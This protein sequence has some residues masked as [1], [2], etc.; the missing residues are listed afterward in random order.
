MKSSPATPNPLGVS[1]KYNSLPHTPLTCGEHVS[2]A[3]WMP[4]TKDTETYR[5]PMAFLT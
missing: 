5:Y 2:S 4:E 3:Q 1:Q